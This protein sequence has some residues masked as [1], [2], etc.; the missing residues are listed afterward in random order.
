M[1]YGGVKKNDN[2]DI[3]DYRGEI[4]SPRNIGGYGVMNQVTGNGT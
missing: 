1:V 2:G 3:D 4:F